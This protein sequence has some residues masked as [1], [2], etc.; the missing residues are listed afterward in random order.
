M[1]SAGSR[2]TST[3]RSISPNDAMK[4]RFA[5]EQPDNPLLNVSWAKTRW[6]KPTDI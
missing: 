6:T 2:R 3:Q 5:N 4:T 1:W